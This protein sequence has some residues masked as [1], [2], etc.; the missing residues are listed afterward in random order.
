MLDMYANRAG[1][2]HTYT[3]YLLFC[4]VFVISNTRQRENIA[5]TAPLE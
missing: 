3:W 2:F 4:V 5:P 1:Q